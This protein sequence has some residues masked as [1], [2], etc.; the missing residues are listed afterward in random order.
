MAV[1]RRT[2]PELRPTSQGSDLTNITHKH[3]PEPEYIAMLA[4]APKMGS[5]TP[6]EG[7]ISE[8]E[9]EMEFAAFEVKMREYCLELINPT[10]RKGAA[11]E[12]ELGKLQEDVNIKTAQIAD[13]MQLAAKVEL[14]VQTIEN[15]RMTLSKYDTDRK[16]WQAEATESLTVMKQDMDAFR[17]QL[18]RMDTSVHSAQRTVDRVAGELGRSQEAAD[19]L[20]NHT[21]KRLAQ[22]NKTL[23][24]FKADYEVKLVGLESRYNKLSDDLWGE[25]TGLAKV[26]HDLSRTNDIVTVMNT[27]FSSMKNDKASI[28][29]LQTVQEEVNNFT[30]EANQNVMALKQTVDRMMGDMKEHFKTATNTVAAHNAAMIAEVRE[31]YQAELQEA[32]ELREEVTQLL[33]TESK[34]RSDLE[35]S[36][37]ESQGQ[38]EDLVKKV[39]AEV[40]EVGK[41]RRRDR[42]S[43]EVEMKKLAHQLSEVQQTSESVASELK[44]VSTTLWTMVQCERAAS[45]LDL[46]DNDD[47]E[48]ISLMGYKDETEK[49]PRG[50]RG[51]SRGPSPMGDKAPP[52]APAQTVINLDERCLSCCG[53]AERVLSGFKMACLRYSPGP[54]QFARQTFTRSHLLG[55][56]EKLLLQVEDSLQFGPVSFEKTNLFGGNAA[57]VVSAGAIVEM[58]EQKSG[59]KQDGHGGGRRSPDKDAVAMPPIQ[60]SSRAGMHTAR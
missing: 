29:Q 10:V 15:F 31:A 52:A 23:N 49:A 16:Q 26:M 36:I 46:Q 42:N 5:L 20:R 27:E 24:T 35:K 56:R 54:V 34:S 4:N 19:A 41:L 55:I 9:R 2:M 48:N 45:A 60:P 22:Q 47:R 11:V 30:N 38:T 1:K 21:D 44:H 6:P 39:T 7:G 25:E 13:L 50:K 51:A 33:M 17:Y 37:C 40:E 12:H 14:Q 53:K 28:S 59:K 43:H 8:S 32:A 58:I 57:S 18:E 3:T